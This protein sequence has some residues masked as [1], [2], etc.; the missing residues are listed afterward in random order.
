MGPRP[1][2]EQIFLKEDAMS[3]RK[4]KKLGAAAAALLCSALVSF[5]AIP[6]RAQSNRYAEDW[7]RLQQVIGW[8]R[9]GFS[10]VTGAVAAIS[11][12][13]GYNNP[14]PGPTLDEIR[15]TIT[16]SLAQ[17]QAQDLIDRVNAL[18]NNFAEIRTET[19][20]RAAY[21]MSMG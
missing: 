20:S 4:S 3:Q 1:R 13:T 5:S 21:Y 17:V 18:A 6:V 8:G 15:Q 7:A 2:H 10:F 12:L 11:W 9:S 14:S 16:D 19:R